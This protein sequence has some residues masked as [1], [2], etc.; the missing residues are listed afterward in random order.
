MLKHRLPI[1]VALFAP[2]FLS[3][4]T[5]EKWIESTP[6]QEQPAAAEGESL[7]KLLKPEESGVSLV[8]PI[9]TNHPLQRAYHSSS[10]C[11]AVAIGDLNLDGKADFFVGNGPGSNALYV[12]T[13]DLKFEDVAESA[14]VTGG[15]EL[16]WAVGI[17]LPDIDNDGDLDIY[18]CNYDYPNQLFINQTI[19][20]GKRSDGPLKFVER[21][22]DYGLDLKDGSV[23]AAFADYDRDGDLD[24]YLL[25]HQVYREEG[26]PA[27]P[28]ELTALPDGRLEVA[29]QWLRWYRVDQENRG[30]N[31]EILYNE[32]GRPDRFL[33][34]DGN[35]KFTE[36]TAEAGISTEPH[37]GNSATWWDYN[38]DG[39]PDIYIG[40]DFKSPDFL[41]RNNGDGTFT[42]INETLAQSTTWFSM[43]AVQ[44]D[45]NNDGFVDFVL[46]DMLPRTHYMRKASMASMADRLDNLE[47]AGGARQL[48][49]NVM[50][51]NTGTDRFVEAG[52]L[53]GIAATE[54][55]WAIRSADFDNDTLA[56]L[57]FV[58]G[59]PRQFNHSDL[60]NLDHQLLVGRTQ[61]DHY[62]HTS[63]RREQNLAFRNLGEFDFED[64]SEK[65]GLAHVGMSYGSSLGDLNGDGRLE[66][67]TTNLEDPVSVY[68]NRAPSGN[69]AVVELRGTQSNRMGIGC[70]L[71]ADLPDGTKLTRQLFPYGGFLDADEPL[72]HFGLGENT[73]IQ[74]LRVEWP[75]GVTQEFKNLAA[76][77]RFTITEPDEAGTKAP[78]VKTRAPQK[79][80]FEKSDALAAFKHDD[81]D[82]DDFS[83]Q[84]LL[85]L[86]LSQ[87]G[88]GQAWGDIDGDGDFDLC[89][90]GGVGQ[91]AQLFRNESQPGSMEIKFEPVL[92]P[93][94]QQ[95][96]ATEDMGMAFFDADGDGDQ[97]LYIASGSVEAPPGGPTLI[98]RLYLNTN[99]QFV[100]APDA[101]P[102]IRLSSSVVAPADFDRDGDLDLFVGTRSIPGFYPMPA[103][104]VLLRNNGNGGFETVEQQ[105]A[106]ALM[107]AGLVTSAIWSDVDSD[108][109]PELILTTEWGPIRIFKFSDGRF[110]ETTEAAGLDGKGLASKGWW[111]GISS[112]DLDHDGDIDF[113]VSNIG[114][115]THYQA[116]LDSPEVLFF[117]DFDGSGKAHIVEGQFFVENGKQVLYPRRGFMEASAAM[118]FLG[119]KMQTFDEFAKQPLTGIYPFERLQTARQFVTN[120]MNSVALINDGSGK[121]EFQQLPNLAQVS[122]G[123]GIALSD[124]DLDGHLDAYLVHNLYSL[125]EEV[126]PFK[127]GLSQ[128]LRGTGSAGKLFEPVWSRESGLEVPGDA[129][130]LAAT[131]VNQDGRVDFIV[132]VNNEQPTLFVNQTAGLRDTRPLR[133]RLQGPAG[134]PT[135]IGAL[136]TVK[137]G[138]LPPQIREIAGGGSY[139][140]QSG[141]ELIFAVPAD[142]GEVDLSVIW[143]DG[144]TKSVKAA[145]DETSIQIA[146]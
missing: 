128:L 70:L 65:W 15:G 85:P 146:P 112:G 83:R 39:W 101:L 25:T 89:I 62:K 33:R 34:N 22:S 99:G 43:G 71:I 136:V 36:I 129:K 50:L 32:A 18:V 127:S 23:V 6:L 135:A 103:R 31:G 7:F 142:A 139:L 37:W 116:T 120:Q 115:N 132:G 52:W 20:D 46:G 125:P 143:P 24:A 130:S 91:P 138:N 134:N 12:Q 58:N 118:P 107:E 141:A 124:V 84:P 72:V 121:F 100:R 102:V 11:G 94:F 66:I 64:V 105:I 140:A 145:A 75:S 104:S 13:G 80:W 55:T 29:D 133:V 17:S 69:R 2:G 86:K 41:Y 45:F 47:N 67:I 88:P 110:V 48:M 90:G 119:D 106:P 60:P 30:E 113:V 42:E 73:E 10:A 137:A 109:S 49:R 131:D 76:N 82:F 26:R 114:R 78:P 79:P 108:Q 5:P 28:I 92:V 44:S 126:G 14:G 63:E 3:A 19:A 96:A 117:G 87:M 144:T 95:D 123:F 8:L 9:D 61:W 98:D 57:Y 59:V 122:P 77:Q 16:V 54:W 56:D 68:Q 4:Q 111:T 97:D 38:F 27:A 21:A 81:R 53:A 93:A 35:G 74:Q 51:I 40:N 1:A